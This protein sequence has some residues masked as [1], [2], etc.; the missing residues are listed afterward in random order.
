MLEPEEFFA[1][2]AFEHREIFRPDEVVWSAL[3][4]LQDY[5]EAL[6]EGRWPLASITGQV[7]QPL[8]IFEGQAREDLEVKST[9]AKG[10]IQAFKDGQV[11]EGASII[12][13]GAY[14]F[15][16]RILIGPE[17][18]TPRFARAPMFAGTA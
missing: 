11:L 5:L 15:N 16:D 2:Q 14:L 17:G 18:A 1:L 3:D 7:E 6:F 10:S 9:G 12:L 8:V 4:R 13:P